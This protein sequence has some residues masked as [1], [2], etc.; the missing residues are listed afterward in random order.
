MFRTPGLKF[1]GVALML[2]VSAQVALGIGN[3][4]MGLPLHNAVMH[5]AGA[6]LLLFVLVALLARL[7][8][9]E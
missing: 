3:V 4:M 8:A 7:R 2:L 6:A 5:T 9:P 1:W